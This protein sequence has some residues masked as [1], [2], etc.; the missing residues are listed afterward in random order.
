LACKSHPG[1]FNIQ[2]FIDKIDFY[3][4]NYLDNIDIDKLAKNGIIC[5]YLVQ[6]NHFNVFKKYL[7][8]LQM[9][10]LYS[11]GLFHYAD[12]KNVAEYFGFIPY[13][14]EDNSYSFQK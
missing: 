1:N 3:L 11:S 10:K 14:L 7:S 12:G 5:T 8:K 6:D 9:F 4:Q 13:N 2:I